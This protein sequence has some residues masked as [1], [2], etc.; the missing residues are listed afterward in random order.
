MSLLRGLLAHTIR[1]QGW[2]SGTSASSCNSTL[3]QSA[4]VT[5]SSIQSQIASLSSAAAGAQI[6]PCGMPDVIVISRYSHHGSLC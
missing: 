1:G 3:L 4:V 6:H 2:L 5:A